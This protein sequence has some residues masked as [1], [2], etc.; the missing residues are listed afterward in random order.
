MALQRTIEDGV[1]DF[2]AVRLGV[3]D[4]VEQFAVVG[5]QEEACGVLIES[6]DGIDAG[7]AM[8]EAFGEEVVDGRAWILGAAGVVLGL[9]EDDDEWPLGVERFT[10][11][12]DLIVGHPIF[13]AEFVALVV[14][15]RTHADQ[16]LDL[17]A[18]SISEVGEEFDE[19]H[20]AA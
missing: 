7:F 19:F 11:E 18:R 16:L 9:V 14:D 2:E 6:A 13:R 4:L 12:A 3:D 15:D 8:G 5:E 10:A 17:F 1:V 20:E